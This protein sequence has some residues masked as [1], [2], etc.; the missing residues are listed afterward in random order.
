MLAKAVT[1]ITTHKSKLAVC[2]STAST[3]LLT[4]LLLN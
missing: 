2:N 1:I 3:E 4:L